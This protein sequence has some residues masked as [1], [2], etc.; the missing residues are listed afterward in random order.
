[1][2]PSIVYPLL[3]PLLVLPAAIA[4]PR[5]DVVITG[6]VTD[7]SSAPLHLATVRVEGAAL[8]GANTDDSGRYVVTVRN[9]A[10]RQR[11]TVRAL[12]IGYTAA[13]REITVSGDTMRVDFAL[14]ASALRLSE[15]VV[16]DAADPT[17]GAKRPYSV[18]QVQG[19][20]AGAGGGGG[21]GRGGALGDAGPRGEAAGTIQLRSPRAASGAYAPGAASPAPVSVEERRARERL[22]SLDPRF[23]TEQYD[24]IY[25]NPFIAART[26]PLSTFSIDVDRASYSNV[27]RFINMGQLP[28]KDAVR[29]EELINYFTYDYAEPRGEHPVSITADVAPAPWKPAHRLVRIGLKGKSIDRSELPPSNL[30]FLI[31]V[32]GSMQPPNKLP[33]VKAAFRLL[34]NELR[35]E[36]HV[37]IVVYAGAAG[38]VL[39]PTSGA[40]KGRI[41]HAIDNLEAGGSTAGGAGIKLAYEIA[42]QHHLRRGNNRVILA[43]DGDFNIGVSSDAEM[44]RLIEEKRE[45]G[46]FLTVLGFGMGN[47]KDSRL[48]KLA[49]KGNGNYAYVDD[50]TEAK[51]VFVTEFGGTMFTIAKDVKLQ[52]EFNP[53]AVSAYRLIGYENRLLRAEDFNDDTKDAGEIG[54]GHTV[55]ALYEVIPVGVDSDTPV[56]GVDPLRYQTESEPG[57]RAARDELLYVKLRYKDPNGDMSK[58]LD[59]AVIDRGTRPSADFVFAAA[60]AQFGL[61]LRDSEYRGSATLGDV[62]ALAR[63]S[64]GEDEHGYRSDFIRLVEDTRRLDRSREPGMR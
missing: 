23:D 49:D 21:G 19:Q 39:P 47:I 40:H 32:S 11:L 45:Q 1:M 20:V 15:V 28:P 52:I 50:L 13:S 29:I 44:V 61:V 54:S 22:R 7:A 51:K 8:V 27:R 2:R 37:A 4:E 25:E 17:A 3:L 18:G 59:R 43:T 42:R 16:T 14:S 48:E 60:V 62:L 31:D 38:L 36:D 24:R 33:L 56:R 57:R 6:R 34:V 46:T 10:L 53:A 26:E 30:V 63:R 9:I 5:Q 58:L 41:L 35:E 12:R 55:T 64:I